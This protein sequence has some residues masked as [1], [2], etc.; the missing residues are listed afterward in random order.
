MATAIVQL[1]RRLGPLDKSVS[2]QIPSRSSAADSL[3]ARNL[4]EVRKRFLDQ[5]PAADPWNI[6]DLHSPW[7]SILP[8]FLVGENCQLLIQVRDTVLME[9]SAERVAAS[10][11]DWSEWKNVLEWVL[12]SEGGNNTGPRVEPQWACYMGNRARRACWLGVDVV[13]NKGRTRY[14]VLWLCTCCTVTPAPGCEGRH[15]F[16]R[17]SNSINQA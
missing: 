4:S 5:K 12:L 3:D 7:P 6:L 10:P 2:V 17:Y 9:G 16:C 8:N 15:E 14:W 13:P 1:F 11:E